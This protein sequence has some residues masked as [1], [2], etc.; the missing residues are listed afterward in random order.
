MATLTGKTIAN[1]YKDL[2]QVSNNNSGVDTTMRTVSDGEGTNTAL[3]LSNA[4]VNING[5]FQLN[6]ESITVNAS[7]INNMAD[8][9]SA[10]GIIAVNSGNVYGRTLTAGTPVSITNANG[11][12]GNPTITLASIANVS[13]SYGPFTNFGVND[14]GQIVS[15]TAVSTSVSIPTVRATELIAETLT[16]SSNAS[17]VGNLNVDGTFIVD[18]IV[19]AASDVAVSGSLYVTSNISVTGNTNTSFLQAVSASIADLTVNTINFELVSVSSFTTNSLKVVA[20]TSLDSTLDVTGNATFD[21]TVSIVGATRIQGVTSIDNTLD[22]SGNA[23]FAGTISVPTDKK[24]FLDGGGDTYIIESATNVVSHFAG[25]RENLKVG[26][27]GVA[28]NEGGADVDFRVESDGNANML[29]VDGGNNKVGI[30]TNTSDG[31]LHVHTASAGSVAASG[32]ADEL[33]LENSTTGG[34][35]ILTPDA[36]YSVVYF[37]SPTNATGAQVSYSYD[38][39]LLQ[40]ATGVVGDSVILKADNNVANLTL[41]GASGSELATFA[42]NVRLSSAGGYGLGINDAAPNTNAKLTVTSDAS[43]TSNSI[44]YQAVIRNN[45]AVS[46]TPASGMLF[47]FKYTGD[48]YLDA[49]GIT[50]KKENATDGQFGTTLGLHTRANGG[51]ITE[52]LTIEPSGNATFAGNVALADSKKI[53]FGAGNDLSIWHDGGSNSYIKETGEGSLVIQATHLYLNDAADGA[54][55]S[56]IL[57]GAATLFYD[58][59]AKIATTSTGVSITGNVVATG[60]PTFGPGGTGTDCI[61]V[62][63]D[64]GSGAAGGAV[65][66]VRSAGAFRGGLGNE[67]AINGSGTSNDIHLRAASGNAIVLAPNNT[68][69]FT[70]ASGGDA[71][72]DVVGDIILDA[73]GGDIIFKDGGTAIGTFANNSNNLRIVSNVSDADIILRGVDGGAAID[74]VT[75]D[76]S[77]AGT[78][79]FNHDVNA[80]SAGSKFIFG[81]SSYLNTGTND[82][83][84]IHYSNKG[85]TLLLAEWSATNASEPTLRF[86]KSASSTIGTNTLVAD[87]EN[88]GAIAFNAAD[89]TDLY[90]IAAKITAFVDGTP[91]ASD[92]PGR[93]VF[94]TTA[95]GSDSPTTALTLTSGQEAI[96]AGGIGVS[97]GAVNANI[98][99]NVPNEKYIAWFDSGTSGGTSAYIR[100]VGGAVNFGGS[101]YTF[102]GDFLT[103]FN[104]DVLLAH[105]GAILKFGANSDVLATHVHDVGLDFSSTRSGADSIFRFKNSANASASDV[106]VIIQNGGTSGGDPLINFDGQATNATWSVGVDTS[107]T[108]FVIADADKG[109]F[110]GSDEVFT[111]ATGGSTTITTADNNAQRQHP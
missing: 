12:A 30:G 34:M 9:G 82:Y 61:N 70:L 37:G 56:F 101:S 107:A 72:L 20:A 68:D 43:G 58:T 38:A 104:G 63:A 47:Q 67:A 78:A 48:T 98:S 36:N 42:G 17:I 65:F 3:E 108:K 26:Y 13:G 95:D 59:A 103:N 71:T 15:A 74:A 8:I 64:G 14:Y 97:G 21:S 92:M 84:Q 99:V 87:D 109:G 94:A 41:S 105:D 2:L 51:N 33:V 23:T 102:N 24:I 96:F 85:N 106:R 5:T 62:I 57:D 52:Q 80:T 90:S 27:T 73:D 53:N 11:A 1:T 29:F 89:G 86:L 49:G 79:I 7:A 91:G 4:G 35:S 83:P 60:E 19:S 76:M 32:Y 75:V 77:D 44:V 45:A 6:G 88:L 10:T 55:A 100:G 69:A 39:S 54:M 110:D 111:I 46:T 16:L 40:I 66:E 81:H 18:G 50:V 22:V 93:L 28:I 25:T 31:T